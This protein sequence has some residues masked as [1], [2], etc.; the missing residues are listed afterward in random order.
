[1]RTV[2]KNPNVVI[3][4]ND[5]LGYQLFLVINHLHPPF[6]KKEARQALMW[7]IKQTDYLAAIISDPK[8]YQACP[9]VFGCGGASESRLGAEALAG[10]DPAKA[11]AM[12]TGS[13]YDGRPLVVMDPA[14]NT[15]L[16][17]AAL[18]TAQMLRR[19]GATVDLQAMDWSTLTQRRA[20]KDAAGAGRLELVRHQRD[21]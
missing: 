8:R 7:G 13:G 19:M 21:R 2:E 1:M 17:P 16:H 6:D 9:A 12:L 3:E 10:F 15:I 20:S 11:K 14:D 5:P 4:P 18:V